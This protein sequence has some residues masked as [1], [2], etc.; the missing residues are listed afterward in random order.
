MSNK[1]S[2]AHTNTQR[3]EV[4]VQDLQEN[5]F[6]DFQGQTRGLLKRLLKNQS[7]RA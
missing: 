5:F 2:G 7:R 3:F 4:F 1:I 6:G